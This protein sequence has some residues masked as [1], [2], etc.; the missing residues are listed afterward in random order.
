MHHRQ[1]FI[2]KRRG[3]VVGILM[4]KPKEIP[5]IGDS[6]NIS[7][8]ELRGGKGRYRITDRHGHNGHTT[9]TI[10]RVSDVDR[11][12][13]VHTLTPVEAPA[14]EATTS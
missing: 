2:C 5:S 14:L 4:L 11:R 6:L 10:E 1:Q 7:G 13:K 12:Y 8:Q 9:V 3:I